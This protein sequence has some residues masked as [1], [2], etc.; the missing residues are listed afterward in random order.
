MD[1]DGGSHSHYSELRV[2]VSK[3][4]TSH[5]ISAADGVL[6]SIGGVSFL[7]WGWLVWISKSFV[8]GASTLDRPI[9]VVVA[10]LTLLFLLHLLAL[11]VSLRSRAESLV[12]WTTLSCSVVFRLLAVFSEP[13]QEQDFYRYLWD[14]QAVMAGVSPYR[15][16]PQQVLQATSGDQAVPDDLLR[17][18]AIRDANPAASVILSRVHYSELPS[19][20]PPVS[21]A[22]FAAVTWTTPRNAL[23]GFRIIV[24]KIW[25]VCFDLGVLLLV[26]HLLRH[27]GHRVGWAL[28]W[29]WSP[30]VIKEFANSAHLDVIAVFFCTCAV[31]AMSRGLFS[32]QRGVVPTISSRHSDLWMFL[33]AASLAL[34]VGAKLYPIVLAPLFGF[35]VLKRCGGKVAVP[36]LAIFAVLT[37][38]FCW[39]MWSGSQRPETDERQVSDSGSIDVSRQ[40]PQESLQVFLTSWK[41][42]DFVTLILESNFDPGVRGAE[43]VEPW[44]AVLPRAW[45]QCVVNGLASW[46]GL[47]FE[48]V[49]FLLARSVTLLVFVFLAFWWAVRSAR[50]PTPQSWLGYVFLTV[51]WFVVLSPTLNPWYWCWA[52]PLVAFTRCRS[53]LLVSGALVLY[54]ARFWFMYEWPNTSVAGT[55]YVGSTFFDFVIVWL[56][57]TPW[58]AALAFEA[59]W[60]RRRNDRCTG[61]TMPITNVASGRK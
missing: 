60:R 20:Y 50:A 21:Q 23:V 27:A 8:H 32:R 48:Q 26:A 36:S 31:Y 13:I 1:L 51:A 43:Y 17:L 7:V 22:V 39:P 12:W 45:R 61:A 52:L 56:E 25:L 28:A 6:V 53:W 4:R 2:E 10:L 55:P 46:T 35:T 14:G 18:V 9:P 40:P 58:M 29:G 41:M 19:I 16:S 33:G 3:A 30:L 47:P 54:Y 37:L 44:F 24:L 49:P 15:Y 34:A 59:L 5:Q 42:N 57:H 11:W 38:A